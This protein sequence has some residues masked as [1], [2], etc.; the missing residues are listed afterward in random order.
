MDG[1]VH[2]V[3]KESAARGWPVHVSLNPHIQQL[4]GHFFNGKV[5]PTVQPVQ[6]TLLFS[7]TSEKT[8]DILLLNVTLLSLGVESPTKKVWDLLHVTGKPIHT[9]YGLRAR[10]IQEYGSL[11]SG[12]YY[13][14]SQIEP[15]S[16]SSVA[17]LRRQM[18]VSLLMYNESSV[19][20]R[21]PPGE[22]LVC[23]DLVISFPFLG[24][25]LSYSGNLIMGKK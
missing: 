17:K 5:S 15:Y 11:V 4:V 1:P 21:T 10:E 23:A 22:S 7:D 2:Q 13:H 12:I 25:L 14:F 9:T 20:M 19:I 8:S 18:L 3:R 24:T 6:I 16:V